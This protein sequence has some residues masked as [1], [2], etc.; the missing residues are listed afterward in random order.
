MR[1]SGYRPS[2][3]SAAPT[4]RGC[5]VDI[6]REIEDQ[7]FELKRRAVAWS[8][9]GLLEICRHDLA[10]TGALRIDGTAPPRHPR[11]IQSRLKTGRF[12]IE[13]IANHRYIV[14]ERDNRIKFRA[15]C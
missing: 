8:P 7:V 5:F 2:L 10:E 13:P 12:C 14:D 1:Q 11:E 15:V 6:A 3:R 9:V 4:S